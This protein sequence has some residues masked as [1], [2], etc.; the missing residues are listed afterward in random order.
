MEIPE[1]ELEFRATRASG[2][3]GQHVNKTSTRVELRW[4]V[5]LSAALS[6]SERVRLLDQLA[7]RL[8]ADGWIRVVAATTRS[9]LRN[10]VDARQRLEALIA[11]ALIVP[12]PRRKTKTPFGARQQRL[13]EKRQRGDLKATRRRITP[14]D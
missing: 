3:G 9:Q 2:P 11:K 8:D 14:D 4:N 10:R 5:R 13:Q 12:K 6:D 7:S 1:T